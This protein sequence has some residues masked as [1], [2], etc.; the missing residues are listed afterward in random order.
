MSKSSAKGVKSRL[1]SKVIHGVLSKQQRAGITHTKPTSE[2]KNFLNHC[3]DVQKFLG[4]KVEDGK[5]TVYLEH[6]GRPGT[7]VLIEWKFYGEDYMRDL[8]KRFPRLGER[9]FPRLR[10]GKDGNVRFP[11]RS[12]AKRG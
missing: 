11:R 2:S 4:E 7:K 12:N 9:R 8:K 6:E 3:Q 1:A 5:H 10:Q